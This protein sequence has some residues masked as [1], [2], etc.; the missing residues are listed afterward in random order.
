MYKTIGIRHEDK[1]VMERRVAIAP[2]HVEKLVKKGLSF[3]VES[4]DKRIFKDAEFVSA[5][6]KVV[7]SLKEAAIVF[8]V[9]EMPAKFFEE[10]KTY[11]FFSHVIKG[12]S[13][14]MPMLKAMIDKKCNLIDYEKI[15]NDE[16]KRLIFFGK[17]AGLAGAI[18]S[19][20]SYGQRLKIQGIT[21]PFE[22]LK[23]AH[24]Y[25]S[26]MEAKA[27]VSKI[28][29]EIST[30][31]LPGSLSPMVI[32]LTG[33]GNVSK[34][35]Q[36]ILNL[37]PSIEITAEQLLQMNQKEAPN[38]II[39]KVIFRENDLS[40]P[41]DPNTKFD[42]QHY[43]SHPELYV[44]QFDKYIPNLSVLLNCMYWDSKYPRIITKDY[45][46]QLYMQGEPKLKVIGDI[47]CDPDGS[48]E[49]THKGT[50]IEDPV[51]VY[52]PFSRKPSMGFSGNGILVMA[53]DIL[54]SELPRES[55]ISFGDALLPYITAIAEANFAADYE[56]L[57]L[58]SS[59]KKALIL[60]NGQLTPSFK[61][62]SKYL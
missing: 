26:L 46:E 47:T 56:H 18:N 48:V 45:L 36:E 12:Q 2:A 62:I 61:Y 52:D 9:K 34:G 7:R 17:F 50:E 27:V 37:L 58:P 44:N 25:N 23:Q 13:Y 20:W 38:N 59:I 29:H 41:I 33:E 55:S 15:E 30:K 32:G 11:V 3:V 5:G 31:G 19:L 28:G 16:G 35:A 4:S 24:L 57:K 8:G 21:N 14:N 1:Y 42:L 54:P 40:I 22:I 43:Y 6:A 39:Y 60:H 10:G 51:F 53:V 49:C